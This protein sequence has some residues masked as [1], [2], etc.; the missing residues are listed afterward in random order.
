MVLALA[1]C[2]AP[3][4]PPRVAVVACPPAAAAPAPLP[5]VRTIERV[6][7]WASAVERAREQTAWALRVC[8]AEREGVEP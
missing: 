5:P 3:K 2:G 4:Q 8:A 1:A 7:A 6:L